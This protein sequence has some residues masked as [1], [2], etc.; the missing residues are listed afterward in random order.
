MTKEEIGLTKLKR[1][2]VSVSQK[3]LFFS[4][5][6]T[7]GTKDLKLPDILGGLCAKHNNYTKNVM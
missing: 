6:G 3:L 4:H 5:K 7:K 2:M 1:K